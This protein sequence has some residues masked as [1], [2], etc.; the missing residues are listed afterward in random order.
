MRRREFISVIAGAAA[1]PLGARA[2]TS[3]RLGI[4]MV[5]GAQS[6]RASGFLEAFVQ[7]LKG[8]G[9]IEGQNVSFEYR[10]A[11]GKKCHPDCSNCH[12]VSFRCGW[13]R[14]CREFEPA[15]GKY[16]WAEHFDAGIDGQAAAIPDRGSAPLNARG[17]FS[18]S[19]TPKHP[20]VAQA[21][22]G[23]GASDR[24]FAYCRG[25]NN[26]G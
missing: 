25:G 11:D 4:L 24:R 17:F 20:S 2:Q 3:R 10:F 14:L 21:N 13:K 12:G 23:R 5:A 1:W 22:A 7:G 18:E 16:Y 26:A 9:W 19:V 15:R 6:A 8:H